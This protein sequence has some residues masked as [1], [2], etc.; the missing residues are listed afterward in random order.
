VKKHLVGVDIGGSK[1]AILVREVGSDREVY[2]EKLKTPAHAGIGAM[3]HLLDEQMENLPGGL[4]SVK[5]LG[6]AV[7]GPVDDDGHVVRAGNLEGWVDVP[8]RAQLE[9]RYQV[10]VFVERDANCGA[11]GEKWLGAAREMEN[12]VFLA[13]GTGVGAG[14]FLNGAIYRGTHFAAGE[15]GD[16]TFPSGKN[17]KAS[18]TMSDVVGK[19]AIKR[20]AR[21]ATGKKLSAAEALE[22]AATERRLRR[23]TG[24]VVEYLG[25]SVV[26]ISSMLDPEAIL[27]GG[28]TSEAGET[29]L[30]RVRESVAPR[31]VVRARLMFAGLGTDAQAYGA[32]WGAVRALTRSSQGAA[33]R[34]AGPRRTGAPKRRARS[35]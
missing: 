20:R 18:L 33:P 14:L 15:V 11:L 9:E 8:L 12:F 27:F 7:P 31:H 23:A 29:L 19:G 1:T 6:V 3:L 26:A 28:G 2:R 17:G 34:W 16:M 25:A 21:R 13:L 35:G 10:P 22:R 4:S 30:K 24:D 5:A 32:L